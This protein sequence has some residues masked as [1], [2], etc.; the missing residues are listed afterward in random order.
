MSEGLSAN[1][2]NCVW[3]DEK[4]FLWI[5]HENGLQRFDGRKFIQFYTADPTRLIPASPVDQLLDA[6]NHQLWIRQG[7]R[8]GLFDRNSFTYREIET[9][10]GL[11]GKLRYQLY[12]DSKKNAFLLTGTP[13]I[14]SFD[15]QHQ[16]FIAG[17]LPFQKPANW[18]VTH[19][20][21]D[22]EKQEYWLFGD[23]GLI[24]HDKQQTIYR[25][26]GKD[27]LSAIS[28]LQQISYF[29]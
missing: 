18:P 17:Q 10:R 7:T 5:G 2:I 21:E 20:L 26:A 28:R 12:A 27:P 19:L 8:V 25:G 11:T 24:R 9:P 6:G 14:F 13:H 23:S 3:Q 4:G 1:K 15:Q 29:L 16:K 22:K